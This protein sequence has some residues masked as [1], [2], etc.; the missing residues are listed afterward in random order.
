MAI[1]ELIDLSFCMSYCYFIVLCLVSK[2][3]IFIDK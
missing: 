3:F 1:V 2:D